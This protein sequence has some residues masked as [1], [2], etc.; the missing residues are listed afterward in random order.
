M[1]I[2]IPKCL[3]SVCSP[4]SWQ[5]P[6]NIWHIACLFQIIKP[7]NFFLETWI[8][9]DKTLLIC[10]WAG[11]VEAVRFLL[12]L[13]DSGPNDDPRGSTNEFTQIGDGIGMYQTAPPPP[14]SAPGTR[15]CR[16]LS[17]TDIFC[18]ILFPVGMYKHC[19][20][21]RFTNFAEIFSRNIFM[22]IHA[23][24]PYS[25]YLGE[26][27]PII[28]YYI[29]LNK[30]I[31]NDSWS[32]SDS[33]RPN[34]PIFNRRLPST[35][36]QGAIILLSRYLISQH[37]LPIL[38]EYGLEKLDPRNVKSYQQQ[39]N[40]QKQPFGSLLVASQSIPSL[41]F[42]PIK[43]LEF[44]PKSVIGAF[45]EE[46]ARTPQ[47]DA[48]GKQVEDEGYHSPVQQLQVWVLSESEV[49]A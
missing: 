8:C 38:D 26:F 6:I 34:W 23:C 30:V 20:Q 1:I 14:V 15:S 41:G 28:Q 37:I 31:Y 46:P 21:V 7:S 43:R 32:K 24:I 29:I 13:A 17:D 35:H 45:I 42:Q 5:Y 19:I 48:G 33:L 4:R 27:H 16:I 36:L 47:K 22:E 44:Q 18:R 39:F 10:P 11:V 2:L 9:S 3:L 40:F 12:Q 49:S 25:T